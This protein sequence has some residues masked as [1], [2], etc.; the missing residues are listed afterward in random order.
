M[1]EN[2]T[3]DTVILGSGCSGL[4]AAI[5]TAR[6]NLKPLV[7]EGHEPGGQLS[8]TTLVENFPGWP[9]GVQGPE[10]I[11]NMKRQAVRFGAELRM[12]HLSS[13][14]LSKHPFELKIGSDVIKTHTLIIASGASARWL[15]LPSEQALIGHGVSSCATCDGFFFSGKEIAVIGGGDSAMEEALFLTRFATKVTLINRSERFRASKIMLERAMAHPQ[16]KFLSNTTVEEVLGVEEK[17]VKGL[18]LKNRASGEESILPVSAMFLGIGHE[19]NAKAFTGLLDLDPDGYILTKSNV[20]TTL[21]EEIVP[22]VFAC[23]D[24]QD[25]RYRQA[26]TAAGSGC[27]AALEVEKYLEEHGR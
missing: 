8:I 23:G 9:E 27:M 25:R 21:N 5:Y 18:R 19:P 6:A 26:I 3:R 4:T 1:H 22:G 17:D 16:I 13:V 11:E 20:F 15:N 2:T 7:L 12:A 24:I 10:L 14:D